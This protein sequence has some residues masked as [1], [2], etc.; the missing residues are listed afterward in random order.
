MKKVF[1][2]FVFVC[3]LFGNNKDSKSK[4]LGKGRD[5]TKLSL[6]AS[7]KPGN[8]SS[9]IISTAANNIGQRQ[10]GDT[11]ASATVIDALP[12]SDSGTTSGYNNDY[13]PYEDASSNNLCEWQGY[14]NNTNTGAGPDVVYSLALSEETTVK[15]SLCG[16]DYDTG[17]GVFDG[18]GVQVLGNDDACSL[19]S[20]VVCALPEGLYYIV[21]DGYSTSSGN[22]V[23]NVSI[24]EDL[25][26][27]Y[28]VG[29]ITEDDGLRDGPDYCCGILY[30]PTDA[31]GYLPAI[32]YIPGYAGTISSN[33]NWGPFLASHGIVT[34][35]VNANIWWASNETRAAALLDGLVTFQEENQRPGSPLYGNLNLNQLAVAGHSRGG[36]AALLAAAAEPSVN[37]VLALAPW[38]EDQFINATSLD[39]DVPVLFL[40]GQLDESAPNDVHTN[41][42]YAYTPETTDKLLYEISGGDHFIVKD[43]SN[44][45]AMAMKALYWLEKYLTNDPTHCD[46]LIEEPT[47]A[48]QFLTNVECGGGLL[49]PVIGLIDDQQISEDG[50]LSIGLSATSGTGSELSFSVVSSAPD[51]IV[52]LDNSTLTATP[53]ENWHGSASLTIFVTDENNLSDDTEFSLTVT[54]VN[55]APTI[56]AIDGVNMDE[57]SSIDIVLSSDDVDGDDLTY[58]FNLNNNDVTL[59]IDEDSLTI[60]AAQDFNGDVPVTIF[61]SDTEFSD[62][63]SFVVTVIAVNDP[64]T[65]SAI[66]DITIIED[67]TGSIIINAEDIDGDD[68][69]YEITS[70][71]PYFDFVIEA[72]TITISPHLNWFGETSLTVSASDGQES[73]DTGFSITVAPVN[74]APEAFT[75]IYPTASDTFS[76]HIDNNNL[77]PFVWRQSHDID[78]DVIYSLTIE[79][80]LNDETYNDVYEGISDTI[81]NISANSLDNILQENSQE[82]AEFTYYVHASDGEFNVASDFGEFVVKREAAEVIAPVI[83]SIDDQQ[84]DEDGDLMI[85]VS[86][87]SA[88]EVSMTYHAFSDTSSVTTLVEAQTLN[89]VPELNWNGSSTIT[90]YATDENYLSDTTSFMLTVSPV[91][92]APTI[93]AI[94]GV[95]MDE[96]SSIDIVL[97]SDDVDGDDLTYSFNLNNNDVTLS[98]DEDSLTITAA[99]DFNGDV[100]VTI[101]VSDTEFSDSTSFVVTVIAVNDP[102]TIS[103]IND[104]TIIEDNTG[105]IIINAEDIDGDD[106]EYEITSGEPYFDFVIE[107]DTITISPHL[108]WF[109]ETS[110]TVSASDGQ[111]SVDTGLSITVT[112]VNDTP[113]IEDIDDVTIDEDGGI[114]IVLSSADVDGDDLTYSF[115]LDNYDV[116]LGIEE[117]T[118]SITATPDFNGDVAIT[119]FVSDTELMDST[120]FTVTVNA[121]NDPPLEFGL[122]SPTVLDTFQVNTATDE[123]IPF[124]WETSFDADSDVSYRLTVTLDYFGNVYTNEYENIT[125]TTTG[126]SAYEYAVLMT[127]LSLPRWNMEY[128]IEASDEEFTIVSEGGEF[129]LENT[130]LSIDGGVVPEVFALHQNYPNPFN[131]VTSLRYD[132]PEDGLVNITVYDMMGRIVKTLVNSSQTAGY[133]SIRWNA[134]NGRNDPVSAGLYIYTIQV[135]KFRQTKK[136]IL[137][138]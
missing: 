91:N 11:F 50:S 129:V 56:E 26:G 23:L 71:E 112:P 32:V 62:S 10:G 123:T 7:G 81:I 122:I 41:L 92:D 126:I 118:L 13:G 74:D 25:F 96:D 38:L 40:S 116:S 77:I 119:M 42:F 30:Y 106:L 132:L 127:N 125:D 87:T 15:I 45:S 111:E 54:P 65:I 99:Q 6:D 135:G 34:M 138:K 35:F 3:I 64:P 117:D 33:E 101:F 114:D 46:L 89:V 82:V 51:V 97:S 98:I 28:S 59:S 113:T 12:Y 57:D 37:A 21:V 72:D 66:N 100:P 16:S 95:N 124:T 8:V 104:I 14:Y 120:S 84:I 110:L 69:E 53:V 108:N 86:A 43:P 105:S 1:F 24:E 94:D 83:S 2:L 31:V 93:E 4:N 115:H 133:K 27:P 68:L 17:L 52:S 134:T 128:V 20:A 48:S 61:V 55:D 85:T 78:S 79:L 90:V 76:T 19:Q 47:T 67:N 102:P 88:I 103:A 63:T 75:T 22:Y 70:G 18:S 107:A 60:T 5:N 137:L 73:V 29:T 130:S 44:N 58:S 39:Q 9:D 49:P 80:E 109:G 36:G 131:P 121:V 136:M